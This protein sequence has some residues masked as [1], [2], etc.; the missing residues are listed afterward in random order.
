MEPKWRKKEEETPGCQPGFYDWF[1]TH[2]AHQL[3]SGMLKPVREEAG[4]GHPPVPFTTNASE[5]LNAMIKQKVVQKECTSKVC[6]PLKT[7]CGRATEGVRE[8]SNW[9]G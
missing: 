5:S 6:G 8:S 9:Q 7:A 1:L 4:L 2:K 3:V